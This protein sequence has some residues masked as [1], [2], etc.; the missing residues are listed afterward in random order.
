MNTPL[1][2]SIRNALLLWLLVL[3]TQF[4][5]ANDDL[6]LSPPPIT[7]TV[8]PG[9]IAQQLNLT[10]AELKLPDTRIRAAGVDIVGRKGS[11]DGQTGFYAVFGAFG[12]KE[13]NEEQTGAAISVLFGPEWYA[14]ESRRT[15]L[16]AAIGADLLTLRAN[17][18]P[19]AGTRYSGQS[20]NVVLTAQTRFAVL[21]DGDLVPF[22]MAGSTRLTIGSMGSGATGN[23][24]ATAESNNFQWYDIGFDL[25]SRHFSLGFLTSYRK[26]SDLRLIRF[27]FPL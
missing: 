2:S 19:N 18:G 5:E 25:A 17:Q 24:G 14:G 4:V 6:N 12:L 9:E 16:S 20:I 23:A 1:R 8:A 21:E 13:R 10:W 7:R 15:I 11:L 22:L 3:S 26:D 27:G